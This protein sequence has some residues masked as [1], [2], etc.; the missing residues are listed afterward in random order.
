MISKYPYKNLT[1]ID[2]ESPTK[3]EIRSLMDEYNIHPIVAN[4]LLTPTIRPKVDVYDNLIYLILHFPTVTHSHH[5][6]TEQEIDFIIGEDFLITTHYEMVDPLHEFSKIF[7][8]NSIL[9]KSS[10][11]NHT[12]YLFYYIIK[13]LYKNLDQE[14]ED[15]SEILE[16][17][18]ENIFSGEER[19]MVEVISDTNRKLLNFKQAIR[20]HKEV[21][22]SFEVAGKQ[23][24][25]EKFSYYLRA[26]TGEYYKIFSIMEGHKETLLDLR[27]TND[28]L[29]STKT[30]ETMKILTI[31]SSIALPLTLIA[32]IFGM[33]TESMPLIGKANDFYL[34]LG[35]MIASLLT[36]FV[37]FKYKKWM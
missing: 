37:F 1:W 14:L 17:I 22:E 36:T 23:F 28:A 6:E 12:G 10:I 19:L 20:A 8:V 27:E 24:F 7:E 26:I 9:D 21:L 25:D 15:I 29:L 16:N 13:E 18:E 32:S 35:F 31:M 30:N 34:V 3:K 4:E 5:G 11:G 2:V 33:N